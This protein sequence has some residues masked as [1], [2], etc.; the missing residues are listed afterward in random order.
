VPRDLWVDIPGLSS[1]QK[2]NAA[3]EVNDFSQDG[4][5]AGGM[6]QLEQ[7]V[8]D[9]FGIPINYYSLIN[10]T[11]FK[12]AVDSVGGITVNIQSTDPRGLYDPNINKHEGGPLK[13]PNGPV[14]LTGRDALNLARARGDPCFCRTVE[15]GFP[16]SDFDRTQHQ[17]QMLV[18]L[19][20]KALTA[21]VLANPFKVS[22][23][24]SAVGNNI[25]TDI[26]LQEALRFIQLTKNMNVTKL[27]SL[28]L[29][30]SGDH[31][32][33]T[34]YTAPN[35]QSA[36]IPK[37]GIDSYGQIRQFYQQLTSDNPLVKESPS[38]VVLNGNGIAGMAKKESNL[39]QTKEFNV[40]STTDADGLYPNTLI[41]DNTNG[42][43]PVSKQ[44]LQ[45]AFPAATFATSQATAEAR[46][47][48]GYTAD[49][50]IILGHDVSAPANTS[51]QN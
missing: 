10:Y 33:L 51:P 35:G 4:F 24:F 3:N 45:K 49:F 37:A 23:L 17:R 5:P 19:Q 31:P 42:Q 43:K 27:Q 40:L 6:G 48:Q 36:L 18:A 46:E 7:I 9:D 20:Q 2:I 47:A 30:N 21:G 11:A 25:Q 14:N 28:G 29:S 32:L 34:S 41:I 50:I 12:D 15:Y 22:Q 38:V 1:H 16:G 26:H 8:Q 39:L 13:L 44:T